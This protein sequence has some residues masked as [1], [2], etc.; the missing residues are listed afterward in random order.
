MLLP[1][2]WIENSIEA[3]LYQHTT[4]SQK[5]YWVVL[6]AIS[7]T[8]VSLPFIYVDITVQGSGII[9][10]VAEKTEIIS[11]LSELVDSVFIRE[12]AQVKK[13][14]AI[15][16]F[17][18]NQTD[19]KISYQT[20]RLSDYEAHLADLSYLSKGEKPQTFYSSVRQ[21]EYTYYIQRRLEL[22][23]AIE[24]AEKEYQREKMLYDKQLI[25][26]EEYEKYY[27]QYE[28]RKN[29]LASFAESQLNTW[30]AD[31]NSYRNLYGEMQTALKQ[32]VVD[33]DLC[34][35]RSPV[36]GTV[37]QFMGIYR[38]SSLQAG[39][40]LAIISPDS[41]LYIE[42]Y[43]TPRDIGYVYI[44]MPVN[45]QVESFN[46][47]QWGSITGE[48]ADISSDFL[49]D[50][51]GYSFYKVK[52]SMEKDYLTLKNGRQGKL[53][54]GMSVAAHFRITRRSLFDLLY[55]KIDDWINPAQYK[56]VT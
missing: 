35:V 52:C 29:E 16:R 18:T 47:N 39:Q 2:K 9:R 11:P 25:S 20:S 53:K 5:I 42:T 13:G 19:Y 56:K 54:K 41:A 30:Q 6:A 7:I 50:N 44:G 51:Q 36:N 48:V 21:R 8:L 26:T 1:N 12:G 10:P 37:D 27:Y 4:V 24:Q 31:L 40:S 28:S 3:Y 17:R 43:V 45:V 15:L 14:D 22:T 38:G 49:T 32:E 55:Q 23:T 46:Y 34:I 33:K